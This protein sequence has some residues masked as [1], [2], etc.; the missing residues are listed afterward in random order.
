MSKKTLEKVEKIKQSSMSAFLSKEGAESSDSSGEEEEGDKG[1]EKDLLAKT[2]RK[3]YLSLATDNIPE[4]QKQGMYMI[5]I[6]QCTY[7]HV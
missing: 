1:R 3:Y 6:I 2:L 7:K 5:L 4:S